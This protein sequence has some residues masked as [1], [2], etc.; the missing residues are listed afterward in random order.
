MR[1]PWRY[2]L[3]VAALMA[4][5]L[6]V[7]ACGD[8][9]GDLTERDVSDELERALGSMAENDLA[10]MVL[11][12]ED[13]GEE[14]GNLEIDDDSGF[15]D[16]EEETDETI[17][18]DDTA[19]DLERAGRISGYDLSYSDPS[20]SALGAGEGIIAVAT[21]LDLFKDASA[22][23]DFLAKQVEDHL[24]LEG[25]QIQGDW[26]LEEV[27]TFAVVGLA[28]EAV[29][30]RA[31]ARLGDIQAYETVVSFTLDRLVGAADVFRAD[32][33]DVSSQ[34][35]GI[36][37]ALEERIRGVLLG[38]IGGTPVPVPQ[39]EEEPLSLGIN[40]WPAIKEQLPPL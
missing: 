13:L 21:E 29:G 32:D 34:V 20:L 11:P 24:R 28:D 22:A 30:I 18:P 39:A 14:F 26:M 16:S 9:E 37:R 17:D 31:R 19:G 1:F 6:V 33:A 23:S 40:T 25:Q 4:G 35:E 5:C 2:V 8:E 15:K 3:V 10:I 12:Q 7:A 36:A 27:E 38:H